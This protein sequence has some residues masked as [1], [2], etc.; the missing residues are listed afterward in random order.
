MKNFE[1]SRIFYFF[2]QIIAGFTNI[3]R[4]FNKK[5]D[6]IFQIF[7]KVENRLEAYRE[8]HCVFCFPKFSKQNYGRN[9]VQMYLFSGLVGKV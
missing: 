5:L 4:S 1:N 7:Y 3:I 8:N 6:L 9:D 2:S